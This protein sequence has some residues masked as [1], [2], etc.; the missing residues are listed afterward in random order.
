MSRFDEYL[1]VRN[2]VGQYSVWPASRPLPDG[3]RATG[4]RGTRPQCLSHIDTVWTDIRPRRTD[5]GAV[6]GQRVTP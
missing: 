5:T 2:D 3:W 4:A 1:V 6:P